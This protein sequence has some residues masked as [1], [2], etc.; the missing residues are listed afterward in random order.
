MEYFTL[1]H[2]YHV[3]STGCP[4]K[5]SAAAITAADASV[6]HCLIVIGIFI[7]EHVYRVAITG[8][9]PKVLAATTAADA[10]VQHC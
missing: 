7:L 2:V 9:P 5:V 6:W 8:C 1:E 3:A 10:G 4:T